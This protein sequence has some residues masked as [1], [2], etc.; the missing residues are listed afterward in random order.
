MRLLIGMPGV[1]EHCPDRPLIGSRSRVPDGVRIS[2]STQ[3]T[4]DG[5]FDRNANLPTS[6][7][8]AQ[9]QLS[10]GVLRASLSAVRSLSRSRSRA[11]FGARKTLSTQ[12]SRAEEFELDEDP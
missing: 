11:T 2:F 6:V 7:D 5:N 12:R 9:A 8:A 1:R 10:A 3:R 4:R